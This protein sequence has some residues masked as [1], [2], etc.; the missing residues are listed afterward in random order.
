MCCLVES[1]CISLGGV[2][3]D[4]LVLSW[5]CG[6][7]GQVG[8]DTQPLAEL[9]WLHLR[10]RGRPGLMWL[11]FFKN[12]PGSSVG[13]GLVIYR[14][15]TLAPCGT[16]ARG[17]G[18]DYVANSPAGEEFNVHETWVCGKTLPSWWL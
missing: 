13:Q 2:S 8:A 10:S 7:L 9:E 6:D 1:W 4:G 3:W 14:K 11:L 5:D 12:C 18:K 15:P 16:W 17:T